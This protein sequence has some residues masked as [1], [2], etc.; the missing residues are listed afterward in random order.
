MKENIMFS[1]TSVLDYQFWVKMAR[2]GFSRSFYYVKN[3][4]CNASQC[5]MGTTACL[6]PP[7]FLWFY[8]NRTRFLLHFWDGNFYVFS[9]IIFIKVAKTYKRTKII[10]FV[11]FIRQ[12]VILKWCLTFMFT[13]MRHSDPCHQSIQYKS[14]A[15][16]IP[17][18]ILL[19][20][21]EAM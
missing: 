11:D 2:L 9:S 6:I 13:F 16:Y 7:R 21:M 8:C 4:K 17:H 1:L 20:T 18:S 3:C 10:Y 19:R 15:K 12:A 5:M 14:Y